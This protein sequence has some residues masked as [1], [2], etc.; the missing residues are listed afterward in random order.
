MPS[1][2]DL[3]NT[4]PSAIPAPSNPFKRSS[5]LRALLPS[6]SILA[7]DGLSSIEI[8]SAFASRPIS[9]LLNCS[10]INSARIISSTLV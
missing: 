3:L 8:M 6:I 7:M 2:V 10:V 4:C 1:I 5:V 9:I